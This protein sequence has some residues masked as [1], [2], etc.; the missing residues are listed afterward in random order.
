MIPCTTKEYYKWKTGQINI[1][2]CSDDFRV[3]KAL[4]ECKRA[5]L[6]VVCFQE[7]RLLDTGSLKHSGY[8][9][10]WSGMKRKRKHGVAIAI[11]NCPNIEI[12]SIHSVNSRLMAVD[13]S[14]KGFKAR[15]VS[16]YAPTLQG[17]ATSTK[18]TF[19]RELTKL[20]KTDQNRKLIVQGDFN[21]E[22]EISRWHSCYDGAKTRA[23]TDGLNQSNE[24]CM[25]FL[26]YCIENKLSILNTWFDHPI[27]HR[28]TWHHPNQSLSCQKVYDYSLC[29]SWTRQ[30]VTDVRVRNSYFNLDH[31][32]LVT[33][34][35]TPS[36]RAARFFKRKDIF[37]DLNLTTCKTWRY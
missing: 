12:N 32:L 10:Y 14:I 22:F 24:N 16:S 27:R 13:L 33:K 34:F 25:F 37:Q 35:T 7:S 31:R 8:S 36:N 20:S 4:E 6:D 30:F 18:Q 29:R 5:N 3:D 26:Q 11:K 9:L 21:A 19:Y 23:E 28:V 2:T 15:I 1:Q 17:S